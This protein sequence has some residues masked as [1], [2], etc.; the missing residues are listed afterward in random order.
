MYPATLNALRE[1]GSPAGDM[2]DWLGILARF[3]ASDREYEGREDWRQNAMDL[4]IKAIGTEAPVLKEIELAFAGQHPLEY[5]DFL[6]KL[7]RGA[8]LLEGERYADYWPGGRGR[9][10]TRGSHRSGRAQLRHP[11]PRIMVSLLDGTRCARRAQV[12]GNR[13]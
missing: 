10:P 12:A 4:I 1:H 9:L 3:V 8:E 7:R 11:A 5:R 6:D 2:S 13:C